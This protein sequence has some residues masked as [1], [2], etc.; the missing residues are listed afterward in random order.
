MFGNLTASKKGG[1]HL[2]AT[3]VFGNSETELIFNLLILNDKRVKINK[4]AEGTPGISPDSGYDFKSTATTA[5]SISKMLECDTNSSVLRVVDV[6]PSQTQNPELLPKVGKSAPFESNLEKASQLKANKLESYSISPT[7]QPGLS[8]AEPTASTPSSVRSCELTPY[9]NDFFSNSNPP[10]QAFNQRTNASE[11]DN[12]GDF[13]T[14]NECEIITSKFPEKGYHQSYNPNIYSPVYGGL[15]Y[16]PQNKIEM[17]QNYKQNIYLESRFIPQNK[18]EISQNYKPNIYLESRFIPQNKEEISQNYKPNIYSQFSSEYYRV[19]DSGFDFKYPQSTATT[20]GS[21]SKMLEY[22]IPNSSVP[23]VPDM[24][25]SRTQN[26][27]Q[28]PKGGQRAQF[29]SNLE[30]ASKQISKSISPSQEIGLSNIKLTAS[31]PPFIPASQQHLYTAQPISSLNRPPEAVYQGIKSSQIHNTG[32]NFHTKNECGYINSEKGYHQPQSSNQR[33]AIMN[34]GPNVIQGFKKS[35]TEKHSNYEENSIIHTPN[36]S[37]FSAFDPSK[38]KHPIQ[39]HHY[40]NTKTSNSSSSNIYLSRSAEPYA[41][42]NFLPGHIGKI[43]TEKNSKQVKGYEFESH[44]TF[45]STSEPLN[46]PIMSLEEVKQLPG[47][48]KTKNGSKKAQQNIGSSTPEEISKFVNII[49][50]FIAELMCDTYAN[51]MCQ[52][53]FQ[54]CN[55]SQRLILIEA[56]Q[57]QLVDIAT[58]E[59]GTHSLQSLIALASLP[60]EENIYLEHL[61]PK[62]VQLSVHVYGSHV[63]QR[64]LVSVKNKEVITEKL[65]GNAK[66]LSKNKLGLCVIKKCMYDSRVRN[67]VLEDLVVLMQD[68]Y[69]NYAIQ[70]LLEVWGPQ[71][72]AGLISNIRGNVAQLC[73]QKFSSNVMERFMREKRLRDEMIVELLHEDKI[74]LL[75]NCPYGCYVVKTAAEF[76]EPKLKERLRNIILKVRQLLYVK[77]LAPRWDEIIQ[78]LNH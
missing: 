26:P 48:L 19:P 39:S 62:A 12:P 69:G 38:E 74:Q 72:Y 65:L 14:K 22:Y 45:D 9:A 55:S 73:I 42:P 77:K 3:D 29:E 4:R 40:G 11:Q 24:I 13:H 76:A 23:R 35:D 53:L 18:E 46:T 43:Y 32:E 41:V 60:R 61:A 21:I 1:V 70:H 54:N 36:P 63:I 44:Q 51:Y 27:E 31:T 34:K 8:N 67:E 59:R 75:L 15:R 7:Q 52:T 33:S 6:I 49:R 47:I 66:F 2:K 16:N 30:K 58:S 64:L 68:P 37:S 25:P 56:M 10:F 78:I 28:L 50:S 71:S 17:S 5:G 57:Y 20:G